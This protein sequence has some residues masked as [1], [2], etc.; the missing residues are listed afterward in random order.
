M[1]IDHRQLRD[2]AVRIFAAGGSEP[3]EAEIVA[4]HL[5]EANLRG[6]DSHGVGIIPSY[7]QHLAEGS[8]VPNRRGRLVKE[9]GA[10]IVYD[11]ERGYGQVVAGEAMALGIAEA[12]RSGLAAVALRNAYHIGRVGAY[13]EQCAAAGL[14]S[15]HFVN[16]TGHEPHVAPHRGRDA[17]LGTNPVCIA[18]PAAEPG[19]P[20]I[21]DMAT[22]KVALGK[23]RVARN[24][25]WRLPPDCVLDSKG[26][27]SD[28]P[29]VLFDDPTGALL[30]FGEHKGYAFS[31]ICDLL[32]G[33]IA[34]GGTLRPE[35]QTQDTIT[36]SMLAFI[37]DP[38]RIGDMEWIRQEVATMTGYVTASPPRKAGEPVL[39][40][41]DP[42]RL[43]RARRMAEGVPVDPITWA[44]IVEA[45]KSLGLAL[46][47]DGQPA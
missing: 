8:V 44:G 42:E 29:Q 18:L 34:G 23:L 36:N 37:L 40:P 17:R 6:H 20:A 27:P 10:I 11:G 28:D 46:P 25:G 43:S 5:V 2:Y 22:S 7:V 16:V 24:E 45:A 30:P 39:I 14:V 41:G 9:D 33:A 15:L 13:G 35:N 19:R 21:L 32:A 38:A 31:L 4:G 3:A 12:E 1:L 47:A 26:E